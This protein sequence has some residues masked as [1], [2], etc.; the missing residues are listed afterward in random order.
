MKNWDHGYVVG[1]RDEQGPFLLGSYHTRKEAMKSF[2]DAMRSESWVAQ[3]RDTLYMA[4]L[5]EQR[6]EV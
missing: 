5:V 4:Q 6:I 2:E 3:Y 1:G